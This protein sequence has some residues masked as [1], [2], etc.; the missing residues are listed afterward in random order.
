MNPRLAMLVLRIF[1]ACFLGLPIAAAQAR[2]DPSLPEAPLPHN[3]AS[4]L[5]AGYDTVH[6]PDATLP[7]LPVKQKF[8]LAY[9]STIDLSS[10]IRAGVTTLFDRSL[11][12]GPFY[13]PG[14]SGFGKLYAYNAANVASTLF[15]TQAVVPS[16]FH[17]DPRY[18]RKGSGTAKSRIWR[19]L[20]SEFVGVSDRGPP[21]PNYSVLLGYAMSTALADAYL[22]A[23]NV[24][25]GKSF[26]GYGI[27]FGTGFG[28]NLL[29]EYGGVARVKNL[30]QQQTDKLKQQNNSSAP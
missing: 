18:F 5:F 16:V 22:P 14:A 20:R 9:R 21:M 2:I 28:F 23:R 1:L 30:I 3:R 4:L 17:Q 12:V 11:G 26:E 10:P 8:E 7:P 25:V 13:G 6:D 15:F 29:H 27:K 19:A 24:S